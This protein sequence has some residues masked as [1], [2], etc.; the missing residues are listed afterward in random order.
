MFMF[1]YVANVICNIWNVACWKLE[2]SSS[3][4]ECSYLL[5]ERA[6][7]WQWT[8]AYD[9]AVSTLDS[10]RLKQSNPDVCEISHN[11]VLLDQII[12]IYI[13]PSCVF[14]GTEQNN[15]AIELAGLESKLREFRQEL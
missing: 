4:A 12:S 5:V 2:V 6:R 11:S 15:T 8:R 3:Y 7:L 10:I 9:E 14:P 1:M 13:Y